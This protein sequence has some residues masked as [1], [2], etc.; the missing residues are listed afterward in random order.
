MNRLAAHIE[1]VRVKC[2]ALPE[3][4][5]QALDETLAVSFEEHFRFQETQARAHA[6]GKL[7]TDEAMIVYR[8]LGELGSDA[9]GGWANG[10]DLATK[11]SV[12]LLMGE[13]L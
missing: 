9:N 7:S 4:K 3:A 5:R 11:V 6:G 8:A 1:E 10:T 12:T 13:L 2:D